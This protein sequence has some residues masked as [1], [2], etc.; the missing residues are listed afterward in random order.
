M[1]GA[2]SIEHAIQMA[3]IKYAERHRRGK[4]FTEEEKESAPFNKP[5][6][7]PELSIL[8]FEGTLT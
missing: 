6:G 1:C 4:D 2:C 5:P 8:S 7:C 3:F